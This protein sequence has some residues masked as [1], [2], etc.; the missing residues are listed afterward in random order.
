M[1]IYFDGRI[2]EGVAE[3]FKTSITGWM[4]LYIKEDTSVPSFE[5]IGF[6]T[7]ADGQEVKEGVDYE[8]KMQVLAFHMEWNDCSL[9]EYEEVPI[10]CRRIVAIALPTPS[11]GAV[12]EQRMEC[13]RH[14]SLVTDVDYGCTCYIPKSEGAVERKEEG[15]IIEFLLGEKSFEGVWYGDTHPTEKGSFW[16]RHHLRQYF[17]TQK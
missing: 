3:A 2:Y 17:N 9:D 6:H 5:L 10:H 4:E 1:N 12:P 15:N 7:F 16:W 13:L 14:K 8:K 11:E